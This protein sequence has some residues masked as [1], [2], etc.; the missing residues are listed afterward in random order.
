MKTNKTMW[1]SF[2]KHFRESMVVQE[3]PI[4]TKVDFGTLDGEQKDGVISLTFKIQFGTSSE[5]ASNRKESLRHLETFV[6]E[7]NKQKNKIDGFEMDVVTTDFSILGD[8][9]QVQLVHKFSNDFATSGF[10]YNMTFNIEG[11]SDIDL[12]YIYTETVRG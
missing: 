6:N 9:I 3:R 5:L 8:V 10:T 11:I 12:P 2:T 4:G 1:G 7:F